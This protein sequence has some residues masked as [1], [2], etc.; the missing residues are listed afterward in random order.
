SCFVASDE[1][2]PL[3]EEGWAGMGFMY[4]EGPS[5]LALRARSLH[6][7]SSLW[8]EENLF[9]KQFTVLAIAFLFQFGEWNEAQRCRVDAIA[10][11]A[12]LARTVIEQMTQMAV[13]VLGADLGADHAVAGVVFFDHVGSL[14][15]FAETRPAAVALEFVER[16]EQRLARH[17][18]HVQARFTVFVKSVVERSLGRR[19]L[20]DAVLQRGQVCERFWRFA[21][22]G[23]DTLRV[24]R[25]DRQQ[26]CH[27]TWRRY[28]R[29]SRCHDHRFD[30]LS[31]RGITIRGAC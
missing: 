1:S 14:D 23:H 28:V 27:V 20:G 3:Q 2:H 11:P 9:V 24:G 29:P 16:S 7:A 17:D 15:R 8:G 13:A 18:V 12:A 30:R 6:S 26:G 10:Q 4:G 25:A 31:P 19:V 21:V 5:L 22:F